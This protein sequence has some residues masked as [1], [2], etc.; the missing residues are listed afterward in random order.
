MSPTR[1]HAA[2]ADADQTEGNDDGDK[3]EKPARSDLVDVV[4]HVNLQYAS[5]GETVEVDRNDPEVAAL[6]ERGLLEEK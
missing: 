4:A 3:A 5:V 6:I 1:R 2:H